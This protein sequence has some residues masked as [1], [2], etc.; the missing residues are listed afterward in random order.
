MP[1]RIY[2]AFFIRV[3]IDFRVKITYNTIMKTSDSPT[4]DAIIQSLRE[5]GHRITQTRRAVLGLFF[6]SQTPL[7]VQ[8]ILKSLER[9]KITV[10]KTTIYRELE[11][12]LTE[13]LIEEVQF[14]SEQMK[15]YELALG[16]HHHHIQ[17]IECGAVADV[18]MPQE[19][20]AASKHIK[21]QTGFRVL[22]HSLEFVGVCKNCQ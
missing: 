7:T 11:F 15:R 9:K 2:V 13:K 3:T 6:L 22:D 12:L 1:F 17:C 8:E 20:I 21:K 16:S 18:D 19:L 14:G 10:N 5:K 4:P